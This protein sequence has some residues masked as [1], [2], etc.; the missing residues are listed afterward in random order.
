MAR[1]EKTSGCP[2][3]ATLSPTTASTGGSLGE[4]TERMKVVEVVSAADAPAIFGVALRV[5][6]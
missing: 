3:T 4:V 5:S 6:V 1:T 2:I